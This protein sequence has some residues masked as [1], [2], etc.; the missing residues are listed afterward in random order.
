MNELAPRRSPARAR[1]RA[2]ALLLGSGLLLAPGARAEHPRIYALTGAH[3]VVAPGNVVEDGT[4][5]LRDGRI[6][7]VGAEIAIPP[8]AEVLQSLERV[9]NPEGSRSAS[10]SPTVLSEPARPRVS[11]QGR[12]GRFR[13]PRIRRRHPGFRPAGSPASAR[14]HPAREPCA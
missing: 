14:T 13:D 11:I 1:L 10:E 7:A 4:V 5:V 8:D 12:A 3:I 6:E 2:L 9:G